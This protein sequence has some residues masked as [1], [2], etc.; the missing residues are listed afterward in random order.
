MLGLPA[1]I[2]LEI[3]KVDIETYCGMLAIPKFAHAVTVGYRL[4]MMIASDYKFKYDHMS[5]Q[6]NRKYR[7]VRKNG[8]HVLMISRSKKSTGQGPRHYMVI[9]DSLADAAYDTFIPVV[10]NKTCKGHDDGTRAIGQLARGW[11]E[12]SYRTITRHGNCY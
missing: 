9:G 1:E 10:W 8:P 3:G 6:N 2:L 7:I 4:D 11:I 12:G 5:I